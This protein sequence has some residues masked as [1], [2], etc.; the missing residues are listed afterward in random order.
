MLKSEFDSYVRRMEADTK[1]SKVNQL[2][3][4]SKKLLPIVDQLGQS[5]S[6]IPVD[7]EGNTW[8]N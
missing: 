6:H 3:E 5:V 7:L 4:L 2:V 8:A 1:E